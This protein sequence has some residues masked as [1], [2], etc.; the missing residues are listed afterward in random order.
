MQHEQKWYLLLNCTVSVDSR[1]A[2][3]L[4]GLLSVYIF[5]M[6]KA[7]KIYNRFVPVKKKNLLPN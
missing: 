4:N 3:L 7:G 5:L 6:G 2:L 1:A